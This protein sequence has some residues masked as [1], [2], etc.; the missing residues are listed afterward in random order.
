MMPVQSTSRPLTVDSGDM[1][2][3]VVLFPRSREQQQRSPHELLRE[4]R[5]DRGWSMYKVVRAMRACA[6]EDELKALPGPDSLIQNWVR[7]EKGKCEPDR[8]RLPFYKPIIARMFGITPDTIWPAEQVPLSRVP[9]FVQPVEYRDEIESRRRVVCEAMS[10][11]EQELAYL[12]A[13]LAVPVP[14]SS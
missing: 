11:L 6:T 2:A 4:L 9:R 14:V 8:N 1:D 10:K 7:W 3:Q 12:N 13:V 5:L